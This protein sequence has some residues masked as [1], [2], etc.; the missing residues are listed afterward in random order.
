MVPPGVRRLRCLFKND[1][2]PVY[3]H[4]LIADREPG[5]PA[6]ENDRFKMIPI[7]HVRNLLR[8]VLRI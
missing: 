6:S 3:E 5:L 2:V 1:V 7:R 8:S 4:Q